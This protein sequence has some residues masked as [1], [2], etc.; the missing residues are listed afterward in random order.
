M[1]LHLPKLHHTQP[2]YIGFGVIIFFVL[3][4]SLTSYLFIG[5][6]QQDIDNVVNKNILKIK[7]A[8]EMRISARERTLGLY[9]IL[10]EKDVFVRDQI[11]KDVSQLRYKVN[12]ARKELE[13]LLND[14]D[15]P[16]YNSAYKSIFEVVPLQEKVI[17][18][19][20]NEQDEAANKLLNNDVL[21]FQNIVFSSLDNLYNFQKLQ[22]D[23][24]LQQALKN[25]QLIRII[26]F[27][28]TLFT[29]IVSAVI[30]FYV[31]RSE[32]KNH[33]ELSRLNLSLESRVEERTK[34][35]ENAQLKV[36]KI[37]KTVKDAIIS[38]DQYG[39]I[40]T[41]N[42]AAETI[43]GYKA[44]E[45]I[46]KN[47]SLLTM[48]DVRLKHNE[49]M[50]NYA[51]GHLFR[52][53]N[54]PSVQRGVRANGETFPI[55]ISLN[56][57]ELNGELKIT[58]ILRDITERLIQE[59]K[60]KYL[61]LTDPLTDIANRHQFNIRLNDS[62]NLAK[63]NKCNFSLVLI[64]LDKFKNINDTYGHPFGDQYLKC[65]AGILKQSCREIDTVSR[66]GGDEFAILLICGDDPESINIPIQ[67]ILKKAATPVVI[68]GVEVEIK[69]SMGSSQ[70]GV[71]STDIEDLMKK[72]DT[73]LYQAK[74]VTGSSYVKHI[75]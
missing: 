6:L 59:E 24:T 52:P 54:I 10:H 66:F 73:A 5:Y 43:F 62:I 15:R 56:H 75:D 18:L 60:I 42:S 39:T 45:V 36:S 50:K 61:A 8:T 23:K 12:E 34:Q 40:E 33:N 72:A 64:D 48:N 17:E 35:A 16:T 67:R 2:L 49:H 3:L 68:D 63:R 69:L 51:S 37:L 11:S 32:Q 25:Q 46:G 19:A 21:K 71:D 58:A 14:A 26:I 29:V 20:M 53:P 13:T 30:A 27:L 41:F 1:T 55:E 65:T 47:V 70:Y 74:E 28:L 44:E 4:M 38:S 7:L 9:K 22:A 31:I 57:M